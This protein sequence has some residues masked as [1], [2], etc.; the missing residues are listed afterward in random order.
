MILKLSSQPL[1]SPFPYAHDLPCLRVLVSIDVS[2]GVPINISWQDSRYAAIICTLYLLIP[3]VYH[4]K[5]IENIVFSNKYTERT[6][7]RV[8]NAFCFRNRHLGRV[9]IML[10]ENRKSEEVCV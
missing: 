2:L 5:Q 10:Y 7:S 4:R 3:P 1:Y 9:C 6:C 8:S